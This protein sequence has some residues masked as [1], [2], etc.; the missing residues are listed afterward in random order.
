MKNIVILISG[1]GS[2]M[3]AIVK[4]AQ[5]DDWAGR[6]GAKVAAVISNKA[7]AKGLVFAR[8]HGIVTEVLD[9]KA[10]ASRE[11]F[12]AA[13]AAVIDR[14]DQP[15]APALVVLA[16]FMRILTPGFVNRY[17]G[18][19]VNIHPSLLPA[20]AGLHTHQRAIDAGCKFAGVTVHQ[21][22]PELDHGPILAQAVVPV[23][24]S[25]TADT[26]AARL[27]TQEHLIYPR[28]IADLLRK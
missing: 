19:L 20:F 1:G 18:R 15:G 17:A 14:F 5:R 28:A 26:L 24:P 25:D 27:L 8:E 9:H 16:G 23:L 13:L 2:N 6:L 22:T 7:D 4:T 11:A 10:F 3:A 21:V 12:D